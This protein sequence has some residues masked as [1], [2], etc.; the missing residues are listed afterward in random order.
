VSGRLVR[1]VLEHSEA[2]G[3]AR[4]LAAA[5]GEGMEHD[6]D[7]AWPDLETWALRC[8]CDVATVKRALNE[9]EHEHKELERRSGGGRAPG[10]GGNPN[11][12]RLRVKELA[13]KRSATDRRAEQRRAAGREVTSA[14]CACCRAVTSASGA[15]T[16]ASASS[17]RR[18]LRPETSVETSEETE[19]GEPAKRT[20]TPATV[21]PP[22]PTWS[23]DDYLAALIEWAR[24]ERNP[25]Y[26]LTPETRRE[27][28]EQLAGAV[29]EGLDPTAIAAG[30]KSWFTD[31]KRP[32]PIALSRHIDM[33]QR[34]PSITIAYWASLRQGQEDPAERGRREDAERA[35]RLVEALEAV[36]AIH[37]GGG[38]WEAPEGGVIPN[39]AR[40]VEWLAARG[41]TVE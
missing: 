3:V 24:A 11:R 25:T 9:L 6:D 31:P 13:A 17:N 2:K 37:L 15:V 29:A 12:V 39:P 4:T 8:N 41:V 32:G 1:L 18:K 40:A 28:H 33:A 20:A 35:A 16:S 21:D 5:V 19:G 14:G 7:W 27:L 38:Q 36:G 26:A 10:G 30:L 34:D 22:A 23:A